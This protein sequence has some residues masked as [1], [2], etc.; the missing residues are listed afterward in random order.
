M[1]TDETLKVSTSLASW[2]R[3]GVLASAAL[4]F[5]LAYLSP[6][7]AVDADG[8]MALLASQSLVE[9][10]TLRLDPYSDREELAYRLE[11][12]YR[13]RYVEGVP[14]PNSLGVP[15]I[16]APAVWLANRFG[17]DMLD[18]DVEFATQNVLSALTVALLFILL[19]RICRSYLGT[20]GGLTVAAVSTLGTSLISTGGTALWNSNYSL[21][22]ISLALLHLVSRH[23]RGVPNLNLAYVSVLIG[24]GFLCRPST[25]TFGL[26]FLVYLLG[27]KRRPIAVAAS[28]MLLAVALAVAVP[29]ELYLWPTLTGHYAPSRLRFLTP[30]GLGLYG[31]LLSPSRG[32]FVFSP[33]LAVVV[34]GA[35]GYVRTLRHDRL[36]RLCAMWIGIHILVV[37]MASGK[38]WG[39]HSYGPRMLVDI[40]PGFAL[41]TCLVWRQLRDARPQQ[42]RRGVAAY[43]ALAA[44]AV[45]VHTGQGLFNPATKLWNV[46]PDIDDDPA[47]A[48]DWRYPQFL[49][50]EGRLRS[51]L[52]ELERGDIDTQ[53]LRLTTH[54]LGTPIMFDSAEVIFVGWY[55]P[56]ESWRWSRGEQSSVLLRPA[57]V[58]P[59]ALHLLEISAGSVG[60][61]RV[62]VSVNGVELDAIEYA[63]FAPRRRLVAVPGRL[64]RAGEENTIE[65]RV[66]DPG[67]TMDDARRLGLALR[68]LRLTP[69][70]RDF[71]SVSYPDDRFF[72]T[73]FS[74]AE[75]GW[76]WTDGRRVEIHYPIGPVDRNRQ[77]TISILAGAFGTQRVEVSLNG[78]PVGEATVSGLEPTTMTH[79]LPG[80]VLRAHRMNRLE[81][82]LPDAEFAPDDTRR[83][84]LAVVSVSM[85][86]APRTAE[87]TANPERLAR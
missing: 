73:G 29:R 53:R 85:A 51:R 74:V 78:T 25:A 18:Q 87:G 38:W 12:N 48:L 13:V 14:Y 65:L 46:S 69:L 35:V 54:T 19:F 20:A 79:S 22:F 11:D 37:A 77:Y 5:G 68:E 1:S 26:A 39:G 81:L 49:A 83:L 4:V 58:D 27:E 76:R 52:D 30:P 10:H 56:E 7:E 9:H 86:P 34:A 24:L 2:T 32:L 70:S 67:P 59:D 72:G 47:L 31:V 41:L 44:V 45:A 28:L 80:A 63:R 57:R 42:A 40:I 60:S 36:F 55:P 17:L 6:V 71:S 84:G 61:Q 3:A 50:S 21:L 43:L 75:T 64:L 33:F 23:H 66:S 62:A 16:S 82:L 8:A 15:I